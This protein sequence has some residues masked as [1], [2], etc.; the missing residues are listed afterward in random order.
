M[1]G[2]RSAIGGLGVHLPS[3]VLSN[4]DLEQMVNTSDRWIVERT[5]IR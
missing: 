4:A 3:R 5:G 2:R 1:A